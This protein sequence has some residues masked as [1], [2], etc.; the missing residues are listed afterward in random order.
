MEN[1]RVARK[2]N[3]LH[4]LRKKLALIAFLVLLAAIIIVTWY[5]NYKL[6]S[7]LLLVGTLFGFTCTNYQNIK[8]YIPGL[9]CSKSYIRWLAQFVY[10]LATVTL[11]SQVYIQNM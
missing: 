10:L 6:T 3:E 1:S 7:T 4:E 2:K 11:I 8:K 5:L 9:N